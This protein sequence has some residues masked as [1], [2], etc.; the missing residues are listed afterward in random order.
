[1][2]NEFSFAISVFHAYGHTAD[3]QNLPETTQYLTLMGLIGC[4]KH[5]QKMEPLGL[6]HL[7]F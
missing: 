7:Q 2:L 4:K 6:L 3:C 5:N 1:M